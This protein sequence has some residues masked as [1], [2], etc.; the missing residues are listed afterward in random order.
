M[1]TWTKLEMVESF[2]D[3]IRLIHSIFKLYFFFLFTMKLFNRRLNE[4]C[5]SFFFN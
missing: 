1:I 5:F 3:L 4:V 2:G